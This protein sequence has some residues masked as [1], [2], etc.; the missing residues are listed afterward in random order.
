MIS[1]A[2]LVPASYSFL[3]LLL[4]GGLTVGAL[5][6]ILGLRIGLVSLFPVLLTWP[7]LGAATL[8]LAY[9]LWIFAGLGML[10]FHQHRWGEPPLTLTFPGLRWGLI[11][12]LGLWFV[13]LASLALLVHVAGGHIPGI[14]GEGTSLAALPQ[15]P[16]ATVL[17]IFSAGVLAPLAE[18]LI[19]RGILLPGLLRWMAAPASI[20]L[21]GLL[22]ALAHGQPGTLLTLW[23]LGIA[24]GYLTYKSGNL[25]PAVVFHLANNLAALVFDYL[26]S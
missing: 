16:W 4:F 18:E 15:T 12:P 1:P 10:R 13:L 5:F 2:R 3:H 14:S 25:W 11:F 20:F 6:L 8:V 9:L 26:I 21:S 22:F 19:F 17:L 7:L 23:F 24:A